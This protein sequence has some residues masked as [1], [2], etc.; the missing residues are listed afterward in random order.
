MQSAETMDIPVVSE[1]F[2]EEVKGANGDQKLLQHSIVTW[3][4]NKVLIK[5]KQT[6]LY[7]CNEAGSN[8]LVMREIEITHLLARVVSLLVMMV[9]VVMVVVEMMM[10]MVVVVMVVGVV[11]LVVVVVMV[12]VVMLM[13]VSVVMVVV[14][15]V[16]VL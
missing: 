11:M 10:V 7:S 16:V 6:S 1:T 4:K 8:N 9:V 14:L 3:G 2:L 13:V 12:E 5:N 15:V